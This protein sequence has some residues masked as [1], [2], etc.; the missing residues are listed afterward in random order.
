MSGWNGLDFLVF[1]I[2]FANMVL[3]MTRGATKE[4]ISLMCLSVALI[5]TIKFT[6][7]LQ[8]ILMSSPLI[9]DVLTSSFIQNFTDTI[10]LDPLS[11]ETLREL[12]F[13]LSVLLW[14]TGAFCISEAMMVSGFVET[15]SFPY[16]VWN[17]KVGAGIGCTRGYI[18]CVILIM[19]CNGH[20]LRNSQ[21]VGTL[22]SGSY[23]VRLFTPAAQK[24]DSLIQGQQVERYYEIYQD[25][26]L[27]TPADLQKTLEKQPAFDAPP[28]PGAG[29]SPSG[30]GTIDT[31]GTT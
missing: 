24:L 19:V 6:I 17:R 23:F 28:P 18:I 4:I 26:N 3:G 1:L 21:H 20:L 10:G 27:F 13:T 22:F 8:H 5:F 15:F 29:V 16:A 9:H 11:R 31:T 12:S 7:P 30:L 25:R 2:F 14:F